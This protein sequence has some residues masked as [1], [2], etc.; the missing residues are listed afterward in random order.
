MAA[1]MSTGI[2]GMANIYRAEPPVSM[3]IVGMEGK[4]YKKA[5][6]KTKFICKDGTAIKEAIQ[7]SI[8]T[9]ES[10]TITAKSIGY[11]FD[12]EVVAEFLFTWS[13]KAK[14]N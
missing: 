1:E 8:R 3:L 6:G 4:F 5:T 13:F 7:N 2:L 10:Q 9:K 14:S 12:N 11:N